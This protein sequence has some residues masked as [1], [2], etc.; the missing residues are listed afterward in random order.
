MVPRAT[1][2]RY[3]EARRLL[4]QDLRSGVIPLDGHAMSVEECYTQRPEFS[5]FE[6]ESFARRLHALRKQCAAK[7]NRSVADTAALAHDRVIAE[8]QIAAG[9]IIRLLQWDGS[10][11]ERLLKLDIAN[12]LHINLT[13]KNFHRSRP[14][15]QVFSLKVFRGYI[16]QELK[17][18]KFIT[19][20]YGTTCR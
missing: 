15:Y 17:R 19:S 5:D 12:D 8:R 14:E 16:H 4:E 10:E 13:P 3:S 11:A 7:T 20:Y 1:T 6:F 18:R 2:W 9:G